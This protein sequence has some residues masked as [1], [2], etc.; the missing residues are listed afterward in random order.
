MKKKMFTIRKKLIISFLLVGLIPLI[1]SSMFI[2]QLSSNEIV[3]K[4][5]DA[6]EN[7]SLSTA[8]GLEQWLD[9][10]LEEIKLTAQTE[11]IISND[12]DERLG[13]MNY[14]KEQDA[15]YETVVFTDPEGIV[16]AHTSPEH[17]GS[18]DLSERDYFQNGMQGEDSIS[19]VLTSNSTGNRIV[20]VATPVM[21]EDDDI[22]GVMSASLNFEALVEQFLTMTDENMEGA[23]AI[24]IDKQNI[25]QLHPEEDLIGLTVEEAGFNKHVM[26]IFEEGKTS[27][28]SSELQNNGEAAVMS[29]APV[30][31]AGYGLYL[32][33][34][35]DHILSV[36]DQIQ[37]FSIIILAAASILLVLAAVLVAHK[38]SKPV[39][40]I[41]E[42][43]K[44]VAQG[45]LSEDR[46]VIHTRDEV[47]ELAYHFNNMT[48][49]LKDIIQQVEQN[50]ELV[51]SS[52]EQLNASAEQSSQASEDITTSIQQV[53]SGAET[54]K[55][56][57]QNNVKAL[58][59]M[60]DGI[61]QM[62][63]SVTDIAQTSSRTLEKA[64]E[65]GQSVQNTNHKMESI[66]GAVA[67]SNKV[68]QAL[69]QRSQEIEK[70]L[71]VISDIAEQ[72]NLLALNAAIEAAR[73]GEHGKGFA[74]VAEEV[75]KLAEES[76]Q[77][78][79]QIASIIRDIQT[80]MAESSEST[81]NV[82]KEVEDGMEVVN[83]SRE[84][85]ENIHTSTL[86]VAEHIEQMA[87]SSEQ[88][89]SSSQ[90]ISAA[91]EEMNRISEEA[92]ASTQTVA[93]SSEEQL[94]SMQ[95][96]DSSAQSLSQ[97]A[98]ELKEVVNQFNLKKE[99]AE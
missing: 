31:L 81:K 73:A 77:S 55:V 91:F 60:T 7:I 70:I 97:M 24:L 23:E 96:I 80:D 52:S 53:A 10:R 37:L 54:Q 89:S 13:F 48:E 12:L 61:G 51:S 69:G 93:A 84:K 46:A 95:E 39:Q 44:R 41:T 92:S 62:A 33:A 56:Q 19:E 6:M 49:N 26:S 63:S 2:Y 21:D 20:V 66:L 5:R 35:M 36:T 16:R 90:E 78:S 87:A 76:Q 30:P 43:V 9:K 64:E 8:E 42:K 59:E 74:V 65:G 38:I 29:Y 17:I 28:G 82:T 71:N 68:N 27:N 45:D 50:A 57:L 58:Q 79:N 75:R 72:T 14:V 40:I 11:N 22:I 4:E 3:A 94:A 99:N 67:E 25:I 98:A 18:L 32:A 88:L 15:A 85:F 1:I 47:G 83:E 34:P 86:E